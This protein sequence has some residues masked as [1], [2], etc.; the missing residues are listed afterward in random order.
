[1]VLSIVGLA[2]LLGDFGLSMAA[3]QAKNLTDGQRNNLFWTNVTLGILASTVVFFLA[4]PIALFYGVPELVSVTQVMSLTFLLNALTAQFRAEVTS[5]L[6]F[7]H[8]ALADVA[9]QIA[10]FGAALVFALL[11]WGYWALVAQQ[12]TLALVTL[13]MLAGFGGWWPGLP[14][15]KARMRDLYKF[16]ANTLGV[17]VITYIT[18]N[19]DNILIG[20]FSGAAALGVYTRAYQIFSLP[21]QQIAAPMTRVALPILSKLQDDPRYDAYVRR[22]HLILGYVFGG[23]FFVLAAVSDPVIE[24]VLGPGWDEAKPIFFI[25]AVGGVFQAIGFVYYWIFLSR[26]FTSLQ[27]RYSL[28]GR[29]IMVGLMAVGVIWGPIGVAAGSAAGQIVVWLLNTCFAIPKTGVRV[30]ELVRT[31]VRPII[32]FSIVTMA[33]TALSLTVLVG[34]NPFIQLSVLVALFALYL[35][36][37]FFLVPPVRRDVLLIWQAVS[38]IRRRR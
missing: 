35:G 31:V 9:A 5:K 1:M 2:T 15:R 12:V 8:M 22:A 14:R 7:K 24:I 6:R 23:I 11:G 30:G 28:I 36:A 37:S 17:Q 20:R 33:A 16:G 3:I 13:L 29:S 34:M 27:L 32:L 25:L 21:L 19:A 18:S 26:G 4:G 10:A 38:L